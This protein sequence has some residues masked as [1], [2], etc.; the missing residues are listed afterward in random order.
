MERR[1]RTKFV[2]VGLLAYAYICYIKV[3]CFNQ[4]LLKHTIYTIKTVYC[5]NYIVD[6]NIYQKE[7][8]TGVT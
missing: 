8:L 7:S 1:Q 5:F 2:K 6:I 3:L 4:E